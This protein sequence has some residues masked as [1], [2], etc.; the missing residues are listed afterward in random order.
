LK[1]A[2]AERVDELRQ[3]D[4]AVTEQLESP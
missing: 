4:Q 1:Y 3:T 2:I